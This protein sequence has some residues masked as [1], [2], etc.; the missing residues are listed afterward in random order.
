MK[1]PFLFSV[2][3]LLI[4]A[5]SLLA[6]LPDWVQLG[7]AGAPDQAVA[8]TTI[9]D[10]S[11]YRAHAMWAKPVAG[12]VVPLVDV[13]GNAL[14]YMFHYRIDGQAFPDYGTAT[15]E[16]ATDMAG[17]GPYRYAHV[18]ASARYDRAPI[19]RYG[20]GGTEFFITL[21]KG[22]ERARELLGGD[23][24]LTRVYYV[25]P[26]SYYEFTSGGSSIV[27]EAHT[28]QR[29]FTRDAFVQY[30]HDGER[31]GWA[32]VS[33]LSGGLD[34]EA[35]AIAKCAAMMQAEWRHILAAPSVARVE[36]TAYYVPDRQK[37]PFYDWSYGCSPTSGTIVVGYL[38][39]ARNYGRAI[40]D[41]F[42][43]WDCVEG[44]TDFQIPQAQR[45][46][47]LAFHTETLSGGTYAANIGPGLEQFLDDRGYTADIF[48]ASGGY[49]N[50]WV[51]C[52]D[53][54]EFLAGNPMVWSI[55][56][57]TH[58]LAAFG[59]RMMAS[60]DSVG[61]DVYV[62][63][64]WWRP[65]EWWHYADGSHFSSA[66]IAS[67]RP[68]STDPSLHLL[69]PRGDTLYNHNGAGEILW[70]GRP[71]RV[72]WDNAGSAN[73]SLTIDFSTDAGWNWTNVAHGVPDSGYYTWTLPLGDTSGRNRLRIKA[74]ADGE[75][76]S[77]DGSFGCFHIATLPLPLQ[78]I[79]PPSGR[80]IT[81]PPVTLI[82]D[83]MA[84]V[85]SFNFELWHNS[86]TLFRVTSTSPICSLPTELFRYGN[87]YAW[88][89]RGHNSM[90]WG[91]FSTSSGFWV[92]WAA[93]AEGNEAGMGELAL[94]AASLVR[95]PLRISFALA[96]SGPVRL[97]VFDVL[98]RTVRELYAGNCAG[99][100]HEAV[101]DLR[102]ANGRA[103]SRGCYFLA[104]RTD[105]RVMTKKLEIVE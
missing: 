4:V 71:N 2:I 103:L 74:F 36:T 34:N 78:C 76:R 20:E 52:Y 105:K 58:S 5:S 100:V 8:F 9:R 56:W 11:D 61:K 82:V 62:H 28:F 7:P 64:T 51:W 92:R 101:W 29:T 18:L 6:S 60:S 94:Q 24:I 15:A 70:G 42:T 25:W 102:D 40:Y 35:Q 63:N 26:L 98:G 27:I 81:T 104:L 22:R 53:S 83:T 68:T 14:A 72:R 65:A 73:D 21:E 30:V 17:A 45:A 10:A 1:K 91:P 59:C 39:N 93:I 12:D 84:F 13:N 89:C 23:P 87:L 77:G 16:I 88:H 99:G 49:Y 43:R 38:D 47:A 97:D 54:T 75:Y 95:Q 85:D 86:D 37:A 57:E 48:S 90:G 41:Y 96:Q 67:V 46:I 50:D 79:A 44:E 31:A 55:S 3:G 69:M 32:R 33:A 19:L 66:D 80:V